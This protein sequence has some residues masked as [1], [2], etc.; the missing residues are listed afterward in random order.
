MYVMATIIF[1][2]LGLFLT[3][4]TVVAAL[5]ESHNGKPMNVLSIPH[6]Y[7]YHFMCTVL[8]CVVYM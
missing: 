2:V 4:T 1:P 6:E 8:Y 3:S 7:V 5:G